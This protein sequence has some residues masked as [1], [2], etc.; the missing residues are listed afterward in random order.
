M[1]F[2][3]THV[4]IVN[5]KVYEGIRNELRLRAIESFSVLLQRNAFTRAQKVYGGSREKPSDCSQQ[6]ATLTSSAESLQPSKARKNYAPRVSIVHIFV[7][8]NFIH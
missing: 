2:D 6:F 1:T 5:S 3:R 4:Y 8:Q 7:M